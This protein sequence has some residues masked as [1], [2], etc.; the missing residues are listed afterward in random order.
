[1]HVGD[2]KSSREYI[3]KIGKLL[4]GQP[5][6][7]LV[8]GSVRDL[9][10]QRRLHDFDLVL[11]G[12]VRA[13]A[14]RVANAVGGAFYML[15]EDR[16]TARV[17]D[18]NAPGGPV[19]LDFAHYRSSD[20]EGDLRARDFTI[21]AM[22]LELGKD[23]QL[24][25]PL[26]GAE[27]A[28][29]GVLRA[30][31]TG[32]ME[33]DPVRVLRGIRLAV[34]LGFRI[35]PDTFQQIRSAVGLLPRVTWERKRDELFRM[36]EGK[37]P[38][39]SLRLLDRIGA[40]DHLL[41][42]FTATKGVAQSAPHILP[43]FE[44]TLLMADMLEDLLHLLVGEYQPESSSNLML[45][46]ATVR[47]GRFR[48][49]LAQHFARSLNPN[50][51]LRG[52]L[53]LAALYHDAGKAATRTVEDSGRIRFIGH[54]ETSAD[55]AAKRGRTL[56]L[57]QVEINRLKTIIQQH[58]RIHN[59]ANNPNLP[60]RRAVYRYF[61]STKEAGVDI[62]LLSLAD[63]LA[64]YGT[65]LPVEIWQR[66]V[67]ICRILLESWW[68]QPEV[69]ISPPKLISGSEIVKLFHV[70]PGPIIGRL[71]DSLQEAQAM[72]TITNREEALD[73]ARQWLQRRQTAAVQGEAGKD[74]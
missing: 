57:S 37:K 7:F 18:R 74:G 46:I 11:S 14:R 16:N 22:A 52:L 31:S 73:Y 63:L 19:V 65:T 10:L 45:G 8:G 60:S 3:R 6:V 9:L 33:S 40:L 48:T 58:M 43:V 70:K 29:A 4:E 53:F 47:L 51:S 49:Q 71:L 26:R 50:R 72:G 28:R 32:A 17:I 62:C 38:G 59:L 41:P 35:E 36:L 2:Q 56:V 24:I 39:T 55:M 30:C 67:D 42:E 66:E 34:M 44:H 27:D 12:D 21:N 68:E 23:E 64:T 15:D 69:V 25:D 1:M 20:L 54:E 5:D 13:A 61:R